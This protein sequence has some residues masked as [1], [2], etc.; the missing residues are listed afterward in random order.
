[1]KNSRI[2]T[3]I[4]L[5]LLT[6]LSSSAQETVETELAETIG[7]IQLEINENGVVDV[8]QNMELLAHTVIYQADITIPRA[9]TVEISDPGGSLDYDSIDAGDEEIINFYF[10]K[11]LNAVLPL[12][13]WV[14]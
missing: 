14:N 1:M 6:F 4:I 7:D 11:P 2:F 10:S 13:N 12:L 8:T 9:K 3:G 5:I